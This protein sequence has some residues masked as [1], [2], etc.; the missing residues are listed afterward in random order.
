MV[1]SQKVMF[2]RSKICKEATLLNKVLQWGENRHVCLKNT[3]FVIQ[4]PT[5]CG[6]TTLKN[7]HLISN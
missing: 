3:K 5:G 6:K 1:W 2:M 7:L 4:K